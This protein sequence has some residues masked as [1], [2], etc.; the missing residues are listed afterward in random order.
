MASFPRH[1]IV[2]VEEHARDFRPRR[3]LWNLLRVNIGVAAH[4]STWRRIEN[5][6]LDHDE[7]GCRRIGA[8]LVPLQCQEAREAVALDLQRLAAERQQE[9]ILDAA[10]VIARR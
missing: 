4:V 8:A 1:E 2:K 6:L 10:A 9:R 7:T 5:L 3:Q